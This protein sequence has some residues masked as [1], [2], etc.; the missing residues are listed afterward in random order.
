MTV[1]IGRYLL[2]TL[3]FWIIAYTQKFSL[4]SSCFG[5][6]ETTLTNIHE[7][8]GLIP[9]PAWWVKDSALLRAMV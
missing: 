6:V 8:A 3:Y 5:T 2:L 4:G 7:D 9:G 1:K